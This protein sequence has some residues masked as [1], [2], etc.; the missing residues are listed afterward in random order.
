MREIGPNT[1]TTEIFTDLLRG[2]I[3]DDDAVR[4]VLDMFDAVE[5]FDD[6]VDGDNPPAEGRIV[7]VL[8]EVLVDM[9]AN[10]FFH[11]HTTTLI[12][13]VHAAINAWL[14]AN[15]LERSGDSH[16]LHL[17]YVLRGLIMLVIPTVIELARGRDAMRACSADVVA[18][19]MSETF[20]AYCKPWS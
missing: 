3:Q 1:E 2:W 8:W 18:F 15:D 4:W 6:L 12:P 9:P 19:V 16:S 13:V 11:R 14:D 20:E 17:S 7:R 10:P 5:F